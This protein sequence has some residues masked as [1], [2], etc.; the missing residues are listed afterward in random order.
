[1]SYSRQ[2]FAAGIKYVHIPGLGGRRHARRDSVNTGWR[3]DSFRGYA[4]YM[5]TP[6]FE[7]DLEKLLDL[8]RRRRLAIMASNRP[9]VVIVG[10][11]FGSL[12]A[13]RAF[14][15][16]KSDIRQIVSNVPFRRFCNSAPLKKMVWSTAQFVVVISA[17]SQTRAAHRSR[18]QN[19]RDEVLQELSG[20]PAVANSTNC[21]NHTNQ[22]LSA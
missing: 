18:L 14:A 5:Q 16:R 3:N 9:R 21:Q 19:L 12:W 11:G 1:V 20:I 7:E 2:A 22:V 17:R 10:A 4:D 15:N 8:A 13:A 6:E